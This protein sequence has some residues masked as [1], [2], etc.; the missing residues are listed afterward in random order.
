MLIDALNQEN[1]V[2]YNVTL[3][4]AFGLEGAVYCSIL[5]GIQ[6]KAADKHRLVDGEYFKVDRKYVYE[7]G[8]IP[9]E[10]QLKIDL[11]LMK[12][13]LLSKH[14]DDPDV[15]KLDVQYLASI[16]ANEDVNLIDGIRKK[17]S[18]N[19]KGTRETKRQA[20]CN[21]LKN[22]ISCSNYELLTKLRDWV[23]AIFANPNNF[24]SSKQIELF[25]QTLNRYCRMSN[26]SCDLDKA[27]DIVNIAIAQGY[28]NCDWAIE[29]Y[30]KGK[31]MKAKVD[32]QAPRITEQRSASGE[33]DLSDEVF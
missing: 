23:D 8:N 3:A 20:I 17:M 16:M 14:A 27:I 31:R 22:G 5:L 25:Q 15:I 10:D 7:R 24:L 29:Y 30:E 1:Y 11:N 18:K 13:N 6:K 28:R 26:D 12:I 33:C 9:V 19:P 32:R 2:S 4:G 21:N